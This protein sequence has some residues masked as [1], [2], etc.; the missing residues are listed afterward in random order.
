MIAYVTSAMSF[1]A[2]TIAFAGTRQSR[3]VESRSTRMTARS[4]VPGTTAAEYSL[5]GA[6]TVSRV[7]RP[8]PKSNR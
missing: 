6:V 7:V 4:V 3:C 1:S 8:S 2:I 5:S